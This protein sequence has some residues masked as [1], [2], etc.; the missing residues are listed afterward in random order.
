LKEGNTHV[1]ELY[2]IDKA[3]TFDATTTAPENKAFVVDRLTS[4]TKMLRDLWY[5]AWVTSA[6]R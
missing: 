3:H 2:R 1:E 6:S 4:G 5:T